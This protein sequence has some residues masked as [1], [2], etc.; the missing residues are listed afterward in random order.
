MSKSC[1][2]KRSSGLL[3]SMTTQER[4]TPSIVSV[5]RRKRIAAGAGTKVDEVGQL[6]KQF[7]TVNKL[8]KT[9]SGFSSADKVKAVKELGAAGGMGGMLPGVGGM[10]GFRSKGSTASP[11]IKDKFKKRKK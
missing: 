6:C 2:A 3:Y 9:M 4:K 8:A 5:P 1:S 10:P 7:D 11:S